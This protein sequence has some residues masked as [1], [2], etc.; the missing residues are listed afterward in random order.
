ME[1]TSIDTSLATTMEQ[2]IQ[3]LKDHLL[4]CVVDQGGNAER[5]AKV[6]VSSMHLLF[7]I[8]QEQYFIEQYRYVRRPSQSYP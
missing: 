3:C 5:T 4:A 7:T 2:S 1:S 6:Y 8:K